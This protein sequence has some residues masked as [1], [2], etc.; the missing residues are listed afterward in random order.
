MAEI[1][2]RKLKIYTRADVQTH[3]KA[4]NCWVVIGRMIYDVTEFLQDH[5]GGDDLIL[6]YAGQDIEGAMKATNGI[7][8]HPHT[9]A[10]FG[11]MSEMIVGKLDSGARIVDE[12]WVA[13]DDFVPEESNIQEDLE[14]CEFLDLSKPLLRQVWESNFSK[15]FYLEQVHQPRHLKKSARLFGYDFLEMFTVTPWY[16]I[17]IIW[18]P[19]TLYLLTR[20]YMEFS[21]K[22]GGALGGL[23]TL[24]CFLTGNVIW[25]ILEYGMHR[26]LFHVDDYLPD[27]PFFLMLHFLL[28]KFGSS[29]MIELTNSP[30][31]WYTPLFT[32]R[33]FEIGHAT[34]LIQCFTISIHAISIQDLPRYSDSQWYYIWFIRVLRS[35]RLY[36]L[37]ITPYKTTKLPQTNEILPFEAP[38]LKF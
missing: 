26:F 15:D 30:H 4:D 28:R 25:T 36:A 3:N 33:R 19:I 20:S 22:F 38:L 13:T 32:S 8:D 14:R 17:P 23:S 21:T 9:P 18:V 5:P 16:V 11:M 31:R 2:Q 6:K 7:E 12:N 10:A 1:R 34:N 29:L 24:G 35:L 37:R 27:R